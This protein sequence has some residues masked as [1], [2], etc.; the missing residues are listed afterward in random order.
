MLAVVALLVDLARG[1]VFAA[2]DARLLTRA[3]MTIGPGVGLATIHARLV[4][5]QLAGFTAGQR[6]ILQTVLDALFLVDVARHIGLHALTGSALRIACHI[7]VSGVVDVLAG[8]ILHAVQSVAFGIAQLAV[9]QG[10]RL[11]AVDAALLFFQAGSFASGKRARL[12]ARFNALLLV[13]VALNIL[14]RALGKYRQ[15]E[16]AKQ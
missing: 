1:A 5:M 2:L 12:Q 16:G 8:A 4:F 13:D 7:I 11:V 15:G 6:A 9:A 10:I 14:L 3:D